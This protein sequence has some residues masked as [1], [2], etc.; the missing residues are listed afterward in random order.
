ML[1]HSINLFKRIQVQFA[2]ISGG[3]NVFA[4]FLLFLLLFG[5]TRSFAASVPRITRICE[6]QS[7]QSI[8]VYWLPFN[9]TCKAFIQINIYGYQKA[10]GHKRVKI[11]SVLSSN[12]YNYTTKPGAG[13]IYMDSFYIEYVSSCPGPTATRS[14]TVEID[15]TPPN[16][17]DPDSISVQ[18]RKTIIG[19]NPSPSRDTKGYVVYISTPTLNIP[20]DTVYGQLSN[21]YIDSVQGFPDKASVDYTLA[22]LDS[23]DNVSPL[24]DDHATI[25]LTASQDSCARAINLKWS[26]YKGWPA[27][28]YSVYYS[29]NNGVNF[30]YGGR[31]SGSSTSYTFKAVTGISSYVFFVR[32]H[33]AGSSIVTSSSNPLPLLTTFVDVGNLIHLDLVSVAEDSIRLEWSVPFLKNIGAFQIEGSQDSIHFGKIDLINNFNGTDYFYLVTGYD[34]TK[35]HYF[36]VTALDFCGNKLARS[37]VSVNIALQV[38]YSAKGRILSWNKY[39]SW[40][41]KV[42]DYIIYRSTAKN[43]SSSW[44][45]IASVPGDTN[46]FIDMDSLESFDNYGICYRVVA[47]G[48]DSS[49]EIPAASFS[50]TACTFGP[51]IVRMPNAFVRVGVIGVF[52]PITLYADIPRCS[53][54]IYNRWG[55]EIALVPDIS[56]G[57]DGMVNGVK[58][59]E[60]VYFYTVEVYGVDRTYEIVK[61]TFTVL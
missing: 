22:V 60:G 44:M 26:A 48:T 28:S 51:P 31:A 54:R 29:I 17:V 6:S 50:E 18:G 49:F 19:W 20:I 58:V 10:G 2:L 11:D 38:H 3:R 24:G 59:A 13:N 40:R 34:L 53:M 37:N 4:K 16:H 41:H 14:A 57:W 7:D 36:R 47:V 45:R 21:S 55:E 30:L 5:F 46:G 35:M 42:L 43:D 15:F 8:T 9:D 61:G 12:Q 33:K 52:K 27:D 25:Y 32:A 1:T 23:C 56:K 39:R